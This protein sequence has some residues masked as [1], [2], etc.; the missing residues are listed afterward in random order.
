MS[1]KVLKFETRS[2]RN[3]PTNDMIARIKELRKVLQTI[4][5]IEEE[6]DKINNTIFDDEIEQLQDLFI[7]TLEQFKDTVYYE[8]NDL[9]HICI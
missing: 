2:I 7:G 6:Y 1:N 8:L 4:E 5:N 9:E 3:A